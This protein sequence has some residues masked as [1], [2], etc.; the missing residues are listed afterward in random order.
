MYKLTCKLTLSLILQDLM[1]TLLILILK[2]LP[3]NDIY[4]TSLVHTYLYFISNFTLH[5][6]M[7]IC[8]Y[9]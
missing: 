9:F 5:I 4:Y 2:S 7:H 3:L 1:V 6:F 8:M